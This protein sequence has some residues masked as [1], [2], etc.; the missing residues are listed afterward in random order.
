[1]QIYVAGNVLRSGDG[2]V[3]HPFKTIQEAAQIARAGDT[4]FVGPGVYREWVRP[5]NSGTQDK[6]IS[7]ISTT[8]SE[9]VISGAEELKNWEAFENIYRVRI[10]NEF[11]GSYNPYV[12]TVKGDWL[13]NSENAP[14][15]GDIFLNG[16]S[17]YEVFDIGNCMHPQKDNRSW[18]P[19]F[20]EFVWYTAQEN[21][22]TVIYANFGDKNPNEENVELSVRKACFYPEKTGLDY[23]TVS[24]FSIRCAATQWAPPTAVQEGMI[25]PNW[26]KGW[27][28]EDCDISESKCSGISLGKYY[29]KGNNNKWSQFKVKDGT[30]TQRETVCQAV[31]EGWDKETVGSHIVRR[32]DIHDCGQTGIVGHMGGAFSIIE[33]NHIHHINNKHNLAGAEIGGI[34]LHAAID[35]V[36]RRNHIDHCTRGIWLDWEAQGSRVTQNFLH[37]NVPPV[38]TV[39]DSGLS[40]GEDIFIEVSH[41]PTLIDHNLLLSDIACRISTQGIAFVHNIIAGS[42]TYV[43]KGTDNGSKRFASDRYTPYHVPHSTK[44]AGFMTILHGDARFYN[45]IFVQK[46]VRPDLLDYC[47]ARNLDTIDM[48]NFICGTC[49]YNSYPS[50]AEYFKTFQNGNNSENGSKDHYYDHLPVY[51]AGNAYFNGARPC[52]NEKCHVDLDHKISFYVAE[53]GGRYTLHT[54]LYEYLPRNIATMVNSEVLGTAF[55]PEQRFENPDGTEIVF[56]RD[57]FGRKRGIFPV[58]GPF[59][60]CNTDRFTVQTPG[61]GSYMIRHEERKRI[62]EKKG[63]EDELEELTPDMQK[64]F[65]EQVKSEEPN[66]EEIQE[67]N[68]TIDED[69]F[70][71]ETRVSNVN[72]NIL[73]TGCDAAGIKFPFEGNLFQVSDMFVKGNEVWLYD[74]INEKLVELDLEYGIYRNL[75]KWSVGALQS[76]D[77][78]DDP[79][80]EGLARTAGTLL[81]I[82]S[83][84]MAHDAADTCDT[85]Q[86]KVNSGIE[87]KGIKMRFTPKYLKFIHNKKFITL[88]DVI[89]RMS[90]SSMD[91]V[92]ERLENI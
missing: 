49:P 11:F 16:R 60:E 84:S 34:K 80:I 92:T 41:G 68:F 62:S 21:N 58:A 48:N 57:Y 10:P 1:M 86:T 79:N 88:E 2:T 25:G 82:L 45:N 90:R 53:D 63:M 19:E 61:F 36:I 35:T 47:V 75:K 9:A 56:D 32:C 55:E 6:R 70:E 22:Q 74:N 73:L 83:K 39:I 66:L 64:N 18:N 76:L 69:E 87:P 91:V 13:A 31:N 89:Y 71:N 46:T 54:N 51:M 81:C 37:D 52:E 12:D 17:M 42:F 5:V 26:S 77:V 15:T 67:P 78:S 27:I 43:G 33:D 38:G 30:Q 14:H 29:Q 20:T 8:R 59:E 7:F 23:I 28:I 44:I 50:A 40:L 65:E 85:I 24:G 3:G 4:V 72:S